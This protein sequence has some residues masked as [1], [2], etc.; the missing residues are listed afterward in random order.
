MIID[1][2]LDRYWSIYLLTAALCTY[3]TLRVETSIKPT[4]TIEK[5]TDVVGRTLVGMLLAFP[6]SI[7]TIMV[8]AWFTA[9]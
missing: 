6:A 2:L 1:D 9:W 4:N 7:V 8:L 5:V 3:Y